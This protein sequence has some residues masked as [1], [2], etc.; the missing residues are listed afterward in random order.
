MASA[1]GINAQVYVTEGPPPNAQRVSAVEHDICADHTQN[2]PD[3]V[4]PRAKSGIHETLQG[5]NVDDLL[6]GAAYRE[7]V[8]REKMDVEVVIREALEA[9]EGRERVL[10]ATCGPRPLTNAVK[11][12]AQSVGDQTGYMVDVHAENFSS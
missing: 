9:T 10:I 7:K 1:A 2:D 3:T 4:M 12:A 6:S 11:D 8:R 5:C